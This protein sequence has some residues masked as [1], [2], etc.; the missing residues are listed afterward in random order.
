MYKAITMYLK[1]IILIFLFLN[2]KLITLAKS[3]SLFIVRGDGEYPPNEFTENSKIKGVHVELIQAVLKKLKWTYKY[4]SYPW[5]RA[6]IMAEKGDV[7]AISYISQNP[8]RNKYLWFENSLLSESNFYFWI[9]AKNK[10]K[11]FYD[12]DINKFAKSIS[13]LGLIKGFYYQDIIIKSPFN[14]EYSNNE[15]TTLQK[16]LKERMPVYFGEFYTFDILL[17]KEKQRNNFINLKPSIYVARNYIAFSKKRNKSKEEQELAHNR[18]I[19]FSKELNNFKKTQ[20]YNLILK[21]YNAEE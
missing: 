12:G 21:K 6:Q 2:F 4:E 20:E 9:L 7:D 10:D 8:E 13:S 11:I 19:S 15:N 17:K 14:L 18:A 16:M 3:E 1:K 5:S